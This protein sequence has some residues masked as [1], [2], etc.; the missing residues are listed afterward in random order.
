[1]ATAAAGAVFALCTA[2]AAQ[3]PQPAASGGKIRSIGRC[4]SVKGRAI[5]GTFTDATGAVIPGVSIILRNTDD[6]TISAQASDTRGDF[7]FEDLK[8]GTYELTAEMPGFKKLIVK[9]IKVSNKRVTELKL[10]LDSNPQIVPM[11][12]LGE[13]IT[14]FRSNGITTTLTPRQIEGLPRQP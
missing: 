13:P 1:M 4:E 11:V 8:S 6:Q 9:E 14:D 7:A 2:A 5:C 3:G 10:S 12:Y